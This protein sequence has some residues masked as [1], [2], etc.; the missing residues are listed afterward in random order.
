MLALVGMGAAIGGSFAAYTSQAYKRGVVRNRDNETVRFTSNYLQAC[1]ANTSETDYAG[2]TILFDKNQTGSLTRDIYIYNYANDNENLVSQ[3]DIQ[4]NLTIKFS[5][6]NGKKDDYLVNGASVEKQAD[7]ESTDNAADNNVYKY[8]ESN[9]MLIGRSAK[10]N[11]YTITFPASD[12]DKLKIIITACP[13]NESLSAT[14][15]QMLAAVIAPCTASAVSQFTIQQKYV[16]KVGAKPMDYDAFNYEVSISSGSANAVLTWKP[17]VVEIDRFFLVNLGKTDGEIS[18]IL[19]KG[20]LEFTMD[21]AAGT[22]DYLI[23][24][25]IKDKSIFENM[26]SWDNMKVNDEK[27]ISFDAKQIGAEG[28]TNAS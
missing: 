8:T 7:S 21:Q 20:R 1:A 26:E 13:V 14:N 11:K 4:Y 9:I 18:E 23:P 6:G 2:R 27:I 15:N 22:G 24:F 16:Y 3:K 17:A 19:T 25:Y 28:E 5:G 12:L 10:W